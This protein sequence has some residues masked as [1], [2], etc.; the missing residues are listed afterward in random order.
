MSEGLIFNDSDSGRC[1]VLS[2]D[3]RPDQT[4]NLKQESLLWKTMLAYFKDNDKWV[5]SAILGTAF[6]GSGGQQIGKEIEHA[7]GWQIWCANGN[8]FTSV[9][10]TT[11]PVPP[12]WVSE[13][14]I[15]VEEVR[16]EP[17]ETGF[18]NILSTQPGTLVFPQN[19]CGP[20]IV[21]TV[22]D[23]DRNPV[24]VYVQVKNGATGSLFADA[25]YTTEPSLFYT[26]KRNDAV[27]NDAIT[28]RDSIVEAFTN[29]TDLDKRHVRLIVSL[30]VTDG[31]MTW[32]CS[33]KDDGTGYR[34]LDAKPVLVA[35]TME[36]VLK[37]N[38]VMKKYDRDMKQ[39]SKNKNQKLQSLSK[40]RNGVKFVF[41]SVLI[42][43]ANSAQAPA[44]SGP[45]GSG[46]ASAAKDA[47]PEKKKRKVATI[48]AKSKAAAVVRVKGTQP[49]GNYFKS[50]G[51]K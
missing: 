31:L 48:Q 28:P 13:G 8:A 38:D 18:S 24:R 32:M 29:N 9:F 17:D 3:G 2:D 49:I 37:D 43:T 4:A 12:S 44:V 51:Q 26:A 30:G 10:P 36:T 16:D 21:F 45:A 25:L 15:F 22:K 6:L 1:L 41:D 20:D 33:K 50:K 42:R 27:K 39:K 19:A 11:Y 35:K 14:I 23:K 7:F 46:P 47:G 40:P 5:T 34:V